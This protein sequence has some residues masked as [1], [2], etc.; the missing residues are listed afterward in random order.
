M[1]VNAS[2]E[3]V[4]T[5]TYSVLAERKWHVL[6]ITTDLDIDHTKLAEDLRNSDFESFVSLRLKEASVN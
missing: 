5:K 4:E 2:F 1:S 6:W 3:I